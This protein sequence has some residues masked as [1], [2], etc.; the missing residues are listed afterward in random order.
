MDFESIKKSFKE[1]KWYEWVMIAIMVFIAGR[2]MVLSFMNPS[3]GGNPPWLTIVNFVSAICG[4]ICVFFCAKANISNFLFAVV[5]TWVYIV[6]LYYWKIWGTFWLE[7]VFYNTANFVSWWYWSKHKDEIETHKT[8]AKKLTPVQNVLVTAIIVGV[9]IFVHFALSSLAGDSWLKL[10][11]TTGLSA[12]LLSWIDSATFSIG[13]VAV[14]LE[15]LRYS[16]QYVWWIIT[17][18]L[19]VAMY[20]LHF[21]PVY[22]T[23]KTIYLVMA[24]I[25]LIN[26]FKLQKERNQVNE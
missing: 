18:V 11:A 17:D 6:Y 20:I 19:A 25:G 15:L 3:A 1:L 2:S 9:T 10:S 24:V 14:V 26:W 23:K 16:E 4:I 22:L 12:T 7:V 21:D 8:K 13:V 5:N